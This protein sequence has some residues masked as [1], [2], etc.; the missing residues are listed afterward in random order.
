MNYLILY[1]LFV[2][3]FIIQF[4]ITYYANKAK[5]ERLDDVLFAGGSAAVLQRKQKDGIY[6]LITLL[7]LYLLMGNDS[8]FF[9][10]NLIGAWPLLLPLISILSVLGIWM[11]SKPQYVSC[12]IEWGKFKTGY[13]KT[14]FAGRVCFIVLYEFFFRG[15]LLYGISATTGIYLSIIIN[16]VL[17]SFIHCH[18][19]KRDITAVAVFGL[20]QCIITIANHSVWPAVLLHLSITLAVELKLVYFNNKNLKL[21]LS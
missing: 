8:S 4:C 7:S 6:I 19:T 20:I 12:C 15:L 13:F 11:F 5:G 3:A 1:I 2:N 17:Y 16:L 21:T 10:F 18:L 14:F 9:N